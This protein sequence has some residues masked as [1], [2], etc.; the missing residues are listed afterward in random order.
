MKIARILKLT[1]PM[2]LGG[3]LLL[4]V[5]DAGAT[6][7]VAAKPQPTRTPVPTAPPRPT[8][9]PTPQPGP[10]CWN[11][12]AVPS[13]PGYETQLTSVS[14]SGPNDVWAVGYSTTLIPGG[15]GVDGSRHTLTLHW[16]G[17]SW[18]VVPSP[19]PLAAAANVVNQLNSVIAIAPNDAWAVGYSVSGSNPYQTLT[20]HWNGSIWQVVP[21][22]NLAPPN[23][24]NALNAV[25]A[26]A[27]NDVWAVGGVPGGIG[28]N[29]RAILMHWNGATWTLTP[30]PPETVYWSSTTRTGV[31][32]VAANDVWAVGQFSAFRWNGSVWAVAAGFSGQNLAAVDHSSATNVWSVGTNPPSGGGSEGGGSQGRANA[33]RFDGATWTNTNPALVGTSND[34]GF[35][36]VT[37]ISP[38]NVWAVGRLNR[39]TLTQQWDGSAW[40]VVGSA[41]G[42][43][44]PDPNSVIGNILLGVHANSATDIWAVG[45]F[46]NANNNP[47]ALIERYVCQ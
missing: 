44:N 29:G 32:A 24:Y 45:Y 41:N 38:S 39:F 9:I 47:Q 37:A 26:V 36:G 4:A 17:T 31:T 20:M 10:V 18:S 15:N 28:V 46:Y 42:N 23:G 13:I 12:V 33:Q 2:L 16:N 40:R 34:T 21:S 5:A 19:D 11:V 8:P 6:T 22:P 3:I 14:G 1:I 27:S 25:S 35:Y 7:V 30:E 43:S